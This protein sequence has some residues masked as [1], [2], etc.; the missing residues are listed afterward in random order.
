MCFTKMK[1]RKK[2]V[3]RVAINYCIARLFKPYLDYV[4]YLTINSARSAQK[5]SQSGYFLADNE[6]YK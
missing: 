4:P 5:Q 2:E 3:L 6:D 1:F